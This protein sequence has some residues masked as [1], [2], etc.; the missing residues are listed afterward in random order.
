VVVRSALDVGRFVAAFGTVQLVRAVQRASTRRATAGRAARGL[1]KND[2]VVLDLTGGAATGTPASAARLAGDD[3]W[4]GGFFLGGKGAWAAFDLFADWQTGTDIVGTVVASSGHRN[5]QVAGRR[6]DSTG[7]A[8]T[9]SS[10]KETCL[11]PLEQVE[12]GL[13]FAGQLDSSQLA[14]LAVHYGKVFSSL[15]V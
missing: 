9:R 10:Q 4:R 1:V 5:S 14:I 8:S 6:A 3:S 2:A 7:T 11:N 12:G 15:T 13:G